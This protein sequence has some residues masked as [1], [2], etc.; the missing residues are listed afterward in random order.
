[1]KIAGVV[2]DFYDDPNASLLKKVFPTKE[3]LPELLKTASAFTVLSQEQ[4]SDLRDEAFALVMQNE[5]K[6][7]RKYACV[8]PGNTA[9]SL[10]YFI[11]NY[12]KLPSEAIKVAAVNL[13]RACGEFGLETPEL[14]AKLASYSRKRDP[15][16]QPTVNDEANWL[17]RTNLISIQGNKDEGR[18]TASYPTMKTASANFVNVS[19]KKPTPVFETKT[20]SITALNDRYPLDTYADVKKAVEY[21]SENYP[22]MS[23]EDRH[24]Y[25]IK[26]AARADELGIEVPEL[27]S[28]YGSP[29][30]ADDINGHLAA[31]RAI[32]QDK[33][34]IGLYSE[35]QEKRAHVEPEM[36]AELLT[37]ADEAAGLNWYWGGQIADPYFATFGGMSKEKRAESIW[38]WTGRLGDYV[39]GDQLRYLATNGRPMVHKHFS[40]DITNAFISDP[41]TIFE[42]LPDD[43]KIILSRLANDVQ[44]DGGRPSN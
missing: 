4:I 14:V 9:V 27:V 20:A 21:F 30:Y 28:R 1:M 34:L 15:E 11:E 36:F 42:S 44:Q 40:S 10:L 3:E 33:E 7:F 39:T 31:R 12:E 32:V 19:G 24:E 13:A 6:V 5:G 16:K 23:P 8:D 18:V 35:L 17:E 43:S 25:C 22:G 41:I 2:L 26:T 37:E 29:Y 38:T